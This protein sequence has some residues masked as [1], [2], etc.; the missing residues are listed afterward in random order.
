[1]FVCAAVFQRL[2]EDGLCHHVP[3][4]LI[5]GRGYPDVATRAVVHTLATTLRVP[6]LGVCDWNPH[7]LDLLLVYKSGSRNTAL[8]DGAF[9]TPQLKWLGPHL[10]DVLRLRPGTND[11]MTPLSDQ[12]RRKIDGL[13]KHP[14]V[15]ANPQYAAEL[16]A[17][18]DRGL[19]AEIE[20][21]A[22]HGALRDFVA[23]KL[24]RRQ[25]L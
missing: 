7:G 12:D 13:V 15:V 9:T 14:D 22:G 1:M 3:C 10:A 18:R 25:Y 5:T 23:T 2:V 8:D 24:L 21:V 6:V 20:A 17:M 16:A 19:K 11:A 4:V